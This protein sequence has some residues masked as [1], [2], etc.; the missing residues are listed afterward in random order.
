ME[1]SWALQLLDRNKIHKS[2]SFVKSKPEDCLTLVLSKMHVLHCG[3][4]KD[5]GYEA[6]RIRSRQK[7][8]MRL[9]NQ[10]NRQAKQVAFMV[11]IAPPTRGPEIQNRLHP[12]HHLAN[13]HEQMRCPE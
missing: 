1:K 8:S 7:Q 5:D 6:Y 4:Q 12:P 3:S 9:Q 11:R 2:E 13:I 10:R